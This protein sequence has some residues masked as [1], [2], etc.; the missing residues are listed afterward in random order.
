VLLELADRLGDPVAGALPWKSYKELVEYRLSK[1]GLDPEK[2]QENAFWAE[3]VYFHAEPG[4][5]AWSDVVGRD[6]LGAPK[7]GRFDLFSRELFALFG[8]QEPSDPAAREEQDLACL[9]HFELPAALAED[10][11]EA[12][13]YPLLLV[14][15]PLITQ[16]SAWPGILPT[17]QE[18]YGLQTYARWTSWVEV[19]PKTAEAL[20]ISD[21]DEVWVES[22]HGKVRVPVRVYPGIWPNAVFMPG[23]L[24]HHT[25]VQWGRGAPS[26]MVVGANSNY[27]PSLQSERLTGQ[28]VANPVR[29]RIIKL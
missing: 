7:D 15:S 28:P 20:H 23:G 16:T 8:S 12:D 25:L 10:G 3:L 1:T 9:P 17:L 26:N 27:L 4:S 5:P 29:V 14:T 19:N 13:E 24:G 6:R 11:P 21:G 18:M 22:P 2:F